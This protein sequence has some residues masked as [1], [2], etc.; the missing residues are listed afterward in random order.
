[1]GRTGSAIATPKNCKGRQPS[2]HATDNLMSTGLI[3]VP[4]F[5]S[6]CRGL[7]RLSK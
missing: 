6:G 3:E 2:S 4:Y 5:Q 1:M 7:I